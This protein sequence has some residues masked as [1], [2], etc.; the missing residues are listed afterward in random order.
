MMLTCL[1]LEDEPLATDLIAGY[2]RQTPTLKLL[3]TAGSAM[4]ALTKLQS[5]KPDIL[6][7]DIELPGLNG[8]ELLRTVNNPP[9]VIVTTAYHEFAVEGYELNVVDYLMK[10]IAY[11]RFLKA[12]NKLCCEPD[13]PETGSTLFIKSGRKDVPLPSAEIRYIESR[14]DY[15]DII[16]DARTITT[17]MTMDLI[18]DLL[19]ESEFLRIHRSFIVPITQVTSFSSGRVAIGPTE[20]P[21][22]RLYKQSVLNQLKSNR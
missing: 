4:E 16:C 14:R 12:V 2:V 11:P 3:D 13:Q 15:L 22:G 1:I 19:P 10:P 7:L 18:L 9:Q 20:L 17:K 21:V 6:F 8:F 5:L